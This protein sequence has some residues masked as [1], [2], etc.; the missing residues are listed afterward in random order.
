MCV[1]IRGKDSRLG[2]RV[3]PDLGFRVQGWRVGG[4]TRLRVEGRPEV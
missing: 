3:L 4:K 2:A 1:C